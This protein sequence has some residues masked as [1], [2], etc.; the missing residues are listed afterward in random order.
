MKGMSC[1]LSC[2]FLTIL[3]G[4]AQQ[5]WVVA[6]DGS[7]DF[8]SVQLALDAIKDGNNDSVEVFVKRNIP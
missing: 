8:K 2:L 6:Q 3:T 4:N 1:L 7:G 5:R